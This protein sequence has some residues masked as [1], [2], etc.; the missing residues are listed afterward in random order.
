[1]AINHGFN[2]NATAST[3]IW[4]FPKLKGQENYHRWSKKMKSALK[5]CGLWDIVENRAI[6]Y[7]EELPEEQTVIEQLADGTGRQ[8][9]TV[10]GPSNEQVQ[11]RQVQ[12]KAWQHLNNQA[13]ELIYS[14][15]EENPSVAIED[16]DVAM[17]R[18]IKL[19]TDYSDSG[20]VPALPSCKS[21]GQHHYRV[22]TVQLRP[23]SPI[24]AQ[25]QKISSVWEHQLTAGFLLR[26]Y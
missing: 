12:L 1:M 10:P 8:R 5:Y 14:M 23:T 18:W 6:G 25:S 26:C 13:A 17:N 16:E 7:P 9:I 3:Q 19:R 24:Y 2:L 15:C 22:A 11:A 20:F 21:F 4:N